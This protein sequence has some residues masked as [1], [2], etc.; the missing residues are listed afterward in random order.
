MKI[1]LSFLQ[2][3]HQY[4][5]P[6][7]SFWQYYI[8]N[9]ITEAGHNWVENKEAD[10]ALGLVP[11]PGEE[12]ERW[13]L[14]TWEKTVKWLK[15]T[16]VDLFLSYL[17]PLQIDIDAI[18]QIKDL[19]IPCVN[20]FCD[21]IR[22]FKKAPAEF[23]PFDLNWVPEYKALSMFEQAGYPYL[24]L[25][26]PMWVAPPDRVLRE[27]TNRQASFIGSKDVQRLLFFESI[28]QKDP[29]IPLAIYGK[30]WDEDLFLSAP[31]S[32]GFAMNKKMV[33]QYSFI[34]SNGLVPYFRKLKQRNGNTVISPALKSK[35]YGSIDFE[36]YNQLTAQ[37]MITLGINRYPSY[38]FPLKRPDTY[39][40]LRDIEAPML[41][42]CYMTEYTEG[43]ENLYDLENEIAVFTNEDDFIEKVN[44][45]R[46]DRKK[47]KKLKING[48][49]RALNDHS[50]GRSLNQLFAKLY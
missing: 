25:P 37:S 10:W 6:A 13:K 21:N 19:G 3:D 40:R 15:N 12:Q 23:E 16:G 29:Q 42:S 49:K 43:I 17:H 48:Q 35:I 38:R 22:Y 27:E 4:P 50:I 34:K 5:I 45:L 39:S 2:S 32:I 47:R 36:A 20:F 8:K 30:G 44:E 18:K 9:G 33:N 1:F 31:Q 41:G 11:K 7:Y 46:S 14:E 26:M 28:V 24:N